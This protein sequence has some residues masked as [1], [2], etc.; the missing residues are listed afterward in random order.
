[1]ISYIGAK[2]IDPM[3]Y[4]LPINYVKIYIIYSS[5]SQNLSSY[6]TMAQQGISIKIKGGK[7]SNH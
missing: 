1:M 3:A 5:V 6:L 4:L 2:Y 7:K